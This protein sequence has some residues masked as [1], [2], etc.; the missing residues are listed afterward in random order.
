M[1]NSRS[2]LNKPIY[3]YENYA[4]NI[5]YLEGIDELSKENNQITCKNNLFESFYILTAN[6]EEAK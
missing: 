1:L 3:I 2:D 6:P 4:N 5:E